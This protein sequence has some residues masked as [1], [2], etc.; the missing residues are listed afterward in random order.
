MADRN[1]SYW[2]AWLMASCGVNLSCNEARQTAER[3]SVKYFSGLAII[4]DR[5][6]PHT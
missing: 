5:S 2:L 6:I 1:L 4:S 3:P